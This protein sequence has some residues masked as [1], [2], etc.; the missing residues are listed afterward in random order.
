MIDRVYNVLFLC[1]GN[2]ARSIMAEGI[3]D[4][5]GEGHFHAYSAGTEPKGFVHPLALE[6]LEHFDCPI[7]RMRS[8]SWD[9][10]TRA[11]AAQM[12][13]IITVCDDAADEACPIW[14]GQ[15]MIAHWSFEDPSRCDGSEEQKREVFHKVFREI[16]ARIGIFVSLPHGM[17]ERHAIHHQVQE[18][19]LRAR[20]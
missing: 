11:D 4:M 14:P 17:L 8:K 3:M 12:D 2:S 7:D 16:M 15:P 20:A 9:E 1:T 5:M 6:L 10:F 19:G 13:F 18:I